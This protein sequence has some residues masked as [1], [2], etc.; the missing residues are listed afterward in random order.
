MDQLPWF[1][2][3]HEELW[4]LKSGWEILGV[5]VQFKVSKIRNTAIEQ[6]MDSIPSLA[7]FTFGNIE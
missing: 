4:E 2:S 3:L 5:E 6:N 1:S 7:Y